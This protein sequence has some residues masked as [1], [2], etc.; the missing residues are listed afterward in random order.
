MQ[1]FLVFILLQYIYQ[2]YWNFFLFFALLKATLN[3]FIAEQYHL[4][5]IC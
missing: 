3:V 2:E 4:D 1:I 5:N